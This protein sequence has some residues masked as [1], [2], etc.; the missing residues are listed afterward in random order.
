MGIGIGIYRSLTL[1]ELAASG[2]LIG[3]IRNIGYIVPMYSV[4]Q[5][6]INYMF[7][8]IFKT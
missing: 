6:L 7:C 4:L 2:V 1:S 8:P 3:N 5:N